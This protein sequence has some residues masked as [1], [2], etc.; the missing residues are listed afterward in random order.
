M[1]KAEGPRWDKVRMA[2][3]HPADYTRVHLQVAPG[4]DEP[5]SFATQPP[6]HKQL[7]V[8]TRFRAAASYTVSS[9]PATD[10][11]RSFDHATLAEPLQGSNKHRILPFYY[12]FLFRF[13]PF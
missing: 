6:K 12:I 11:G 5:V 13:T 2:S 1:A 10:S 4:Q 3:D 8:R 7:K 9:T